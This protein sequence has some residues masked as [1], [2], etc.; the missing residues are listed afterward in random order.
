MI[1]HAKLVPAARALPVAR[2]HILL[3][4]LSAERVT[5]LGDH[6]VLAPLSTHRAVEDL[7]EGGNLEL[8]L[9]HGGALDRHPAQLLHAGRQR[10]VVLLQA[11]PLDCLLV[12]PAAVRGS[13]G[14][15][16]LAYKVER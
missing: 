9:L 11:L 14:R 3:D 10:S 6:G 4:T 16:E 12:K 13:P 1:I 5:A 2:L 15:C 7:P 8:E